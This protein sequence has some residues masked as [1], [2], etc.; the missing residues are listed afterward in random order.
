MKMRIMIL[1]K[2]RIM[3][4]MIN[5]PRHLPPINR[6]AE[7]ILILNNPFINFV[8]DVNREERRYSKSN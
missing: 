1:M 2:M 5:E 3:I 4:L 8:N 6:L 7:R